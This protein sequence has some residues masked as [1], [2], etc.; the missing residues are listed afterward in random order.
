MRFSY[1][2]IKKLAPVVKSKNDLIEKLNLYSFEAEDLGG[3]VVDISL[4]PNR[5][6]DT[7]S[8]LGIAKEIAAVYGKKLKDFKIKT[9]KSVI[10]HGFAVEIKEKKLCK[11][12]AAQYFEGIKIDRKSTRLNSS[13][14]DISRMPSSA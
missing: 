1:F 9:I 5:Y 8:H 14:T 11:R 13:H 6:S 7:A 3:D 2:L 4:P 10:K 12:A